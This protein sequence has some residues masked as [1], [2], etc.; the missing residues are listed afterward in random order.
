M[1]PILDFSEI[2]DFERVTELPLAG[3]RRVRRCHGL[4]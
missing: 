2:G 3:E 1:M 4:T